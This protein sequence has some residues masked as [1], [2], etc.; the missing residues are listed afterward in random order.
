MGMQSCITALENSWAFGQLDI[1]FPHVPV[2]PVLG[3]DMVWYPYPNLILDCISH[4]PHVSWEVPGG[5]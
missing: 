5:R 2:I 1:Q 4:K 3:I